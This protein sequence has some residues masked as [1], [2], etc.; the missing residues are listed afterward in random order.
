MTCGI[1][2]VSFNATV[3]VRSNGEAA[4]VLCW[5]GLH[6]LHAPVHRMTETDAVARALYF[7]R[8]GFYDRADEVLQM[9]LDGRH[10]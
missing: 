1:S 4:A 9:Y 3:A 6:R 10:I 7:E 5:D 8:R 2:S